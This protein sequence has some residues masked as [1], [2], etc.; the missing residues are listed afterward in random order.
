MN[1]NDVN[2]AFKILLEEIERV[3]NMISKKRRR[4]L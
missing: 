4:S 2:D 3:F 1:N